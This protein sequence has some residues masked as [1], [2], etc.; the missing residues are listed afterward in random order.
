MFLSTLGSEA[1]FFLSSQAASSS[2]SLSVLHVLCFGSRVGFVPKLSRSKCTKEK[3]KYPIGAQEALRRQKLAA[4]A[5]LRA[6]F[7]EKEKLL[8]E[9]YNNSLRRVDQQI[10][11]AEGLTGSDPCCN[12]WC[13]QA[14]SDEFPSS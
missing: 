2:E 7:K 10:Q 13:Q 6:E 12:R 9:H 8:E 11:E 3:D 5:V 14:C 4:E 1:C